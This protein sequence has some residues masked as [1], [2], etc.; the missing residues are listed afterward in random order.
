MKNGFSPNL[1]GSGP[2]AL[3]P[4]VSL[5]TWQT[6]FSLLVVS[7]CLPP[8]HSQFFESQ[9]I[10]LRSP[11]EQLCTNSIELYYAIA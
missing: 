2:G 3:S 10:Q 7:N 1:L 8:L 11:T 5:T 6:S 4:F 9:A